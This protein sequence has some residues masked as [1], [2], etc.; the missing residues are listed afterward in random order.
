MDSGGKLGGELEGELNSERTN[1]YTSKF[2]NQA[3]RRVDLIIRGD[4]FYQIYQLE[5]INEYY[6]S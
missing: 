1:E 4:W 2:S 3:G 6:F 5:H